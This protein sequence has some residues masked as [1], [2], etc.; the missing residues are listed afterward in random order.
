MIDHSYNNVISYLIKSDFTGYDPYDGASSKL[1]WV[2]GNKYTR[3]LAT[4]V[5]K[6][7]P[8]NLR[9]FLKIPKSKQNQALAFIARAMMHKYD[10]SSNEI[11]KFI[12]TS[13]SR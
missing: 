5:N 6:F 12:R 3:I 13:Y 7:S 2:N 8:V 10:R 1:K 11:R 4:Y 9:P